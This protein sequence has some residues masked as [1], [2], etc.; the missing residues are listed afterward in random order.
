VGEGDGVRWGPPGVKASLTGK[1]VGAGAAHA[2]RHTTYNGTTASL[3]RRAPSG[4]TRLA[5]ISIVCISLAI[6]CW[7]I[8]ST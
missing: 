5:R 2:I 6:L 3:A 1:A 4:I 8:L 7:T